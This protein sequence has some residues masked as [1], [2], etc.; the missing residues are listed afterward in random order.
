MSSEQRLEMIDLFQD[1]VNKKDSLD[2]SRS[3]LKDKQSQIKGLDTRI[4]ENSSGLVSENVD[5]VLQKTAVINEIAKEKD[6]LIKQ[7]PD[8]ETLLESN[9]LE[10]IE[11]SERLRV[12]LDSLPPLVKAPSRTP[13]RTPSSK[14]PEITS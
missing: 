5:L 7:L 9:R 13:S 4:A 12:L 8:V 11:V 3:I 2:Q 6:V 10:Y 1:Y 14:C